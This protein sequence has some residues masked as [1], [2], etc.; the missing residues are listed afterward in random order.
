MSSFGADM[1]AIGQI[2]PGLIALLDRMR[3]YTP[4]FNA[5]ILPAGADVSR[6]VLVDNGVGYQAVCETEFSD[7]EPAYDIWFHGVGEP[8]LVRA[9]FDIDMAAYFLVQKYNTSK[10]ARQQERA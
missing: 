8:Q 10:S 9:H 4:K 2:S 7:G 6:L 5:A 3:T 1:T